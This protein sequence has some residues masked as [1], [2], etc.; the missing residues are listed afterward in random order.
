M[1][2]IVGSRVGLNVGVLVGDLVG[3]TV[4]LLVLFLHNGIGLVSSASQKPEHGKSFHPPSVNGL[5]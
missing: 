5:M 3:L 1:G 2:S 4:G